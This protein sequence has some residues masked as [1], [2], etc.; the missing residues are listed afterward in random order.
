[1]EAALAA[2]RYE[3][4]L[5]ENERADAPAM[6]AVMGGGGGGGL[7]EQEVSALR[8][9]VALL[10]KQLGDLQT[11]EDSDEWDGTLESAHVALREAAERLM[12]GDESVQPEFDQWDKRISTHP[13]HLAAEARKLAEWE[14]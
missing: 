8:A 7:S 6:G 3:R 4:Q 2:E 12:E 5:L 13:D 14:R 10:Q 1:M 11:D 9:K